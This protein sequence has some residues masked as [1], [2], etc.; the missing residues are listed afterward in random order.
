[1]RRL[2]LLLFL[3]FLFAPRAAWGQ[4]NYRAIPTGG[5]SALMGNTGVAEARDGAAPFLNPATIAG[6]ADT[7]IAF[8][9][10]AYAA[11]F[12]RI[13]SFHAPRGGATFSD[14]TL[15][16]AHLDALPSTFCLFLTLD[17]IAAKAKEL[18]PRRSKLALCAGT[19]ERRTLASSD[20]ASGK[21]A[22]GRATL[23]IASLDRSYSRIHVGPTFGSTL[24]DTWSFGA[25]LHV[26][27]TRANAITTADGST[28]APAG[29]DATAF[30]QSVTASSFDAALLL[31][32]TYR[33]DARTRFGLSFAPP[34]LHVASSMS[35][36]D[37]S[38]RTGAAGDSRTRAGDGSFSAPLPMRAAAGLSTRIGQLHL[39]LDT[40]VFFPK[41]EAFV[42]EADVRT[43]ASSGGAASDTTSRTRAVVGADTVVDTGLG[44]ELFVSPDISVLGGL[45]T[46]FGATPRLDASPPLGSVAIT[47]EDRLLASFGIGS[48]GS[49]TE[50][51]F[52]LQFAAAR[53]E[54]LVADSFAAPADLAPAK[55]SSYTVLFVVAGS[56]SLTT[57]RRTFEDIRHTLPIR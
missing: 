55:Q 4:G 24:G 31:G 34:S 26:V 33:V 36:I 27:D 2:A 49:G 37:H 30:S 47:R 40:T 42:S 56:T 15:T 54:V 18:D 35:A 50:L 46:D 9:V 41:A 32:L 43:I 14:E 52:G 25:S 21:T 6:V 48:Y 51:L 17:E 10:N 1:M 11:T 39:Q 22:D 8:S 3:G 29:V 7:Q 57:I 53:G 13:H 44:A 5:R 20:S 19:S 38:D 45:A 23:H 16:D 28:F 12:T